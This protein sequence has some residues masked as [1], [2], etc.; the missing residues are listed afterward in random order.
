MERR[1]FAV[2][3]VIAGVVMGLL[4]MMLVRRRLERLLLT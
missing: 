1:S 2:A 4:G 3:A